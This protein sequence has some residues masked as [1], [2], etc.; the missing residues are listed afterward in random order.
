MGHGGFTVDV[1]ALQTMVTRLQA[2]RGDLAT[3]PASQR[4]DPEATG[5]HPLSAAVG[6]FVGRWDDG[7]ERIDRNLATV[8]SALESVVAAYAAADDA[9]RAAMNG[10]SL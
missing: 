10:Q 4:L 5:S 3:A 6:E 9:A 1:G 7:R 2:L 8:T